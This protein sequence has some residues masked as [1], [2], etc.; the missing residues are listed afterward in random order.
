[1]APARRQLKAPAG[2]DHRPLLQ[3]LCVSAAGLLL[4]LGFAL[5]ASEVAEGDTGGADL[6]LLRAAQALRVAHPGLASAMRDFSGLGSASVLTLFTLLAAGYLGL[7]S[8]GRTAAVVLLSVASGSAMVELFKLAFGRLRPDAAYAEIVVAGPGFPS[9]HAGVA[10]IVYLTLGALL[11]V[12]RRRTAERLFV[13]AA[14]ALLAVLVG[15]SRVAL[16][17]HWGTD[18]LGGWAFGAAWAAFGLQL[19]RTLARRHPLRP[20]PPRP[21]DATRAPSRGLR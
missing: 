7:R 2:A 9:G 15:L 8:A 20:V 10:A 4:C 1:M 16:G 6:R 21:P 5:L 11:A 13:L 19:D 18:V 14:A 17:V 12:S 3:G